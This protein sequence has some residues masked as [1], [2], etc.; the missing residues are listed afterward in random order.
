MPSERSSV[1]RCREN[2]L[3]VGGSLDPLE[4]ALLVTT[5]LRMMRALAAGWRRVGQRASERCGR[6]V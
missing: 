6:G 2:R 1:Q 5:T 3:A 4:V